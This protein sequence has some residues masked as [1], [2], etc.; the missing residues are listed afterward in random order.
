MSIIDGLRSYHQL[1]GWRGVLLVARARISRKPIQI[2]IESPHLA[3]PVYLRMRTTDVSLYDEIIN[4]AE[5]GFEVR[6]EPRVIVD[7]GANIGL[8]SVFF[9]DRYKQAKVL[10]VEPEPSNFVMLQKNTAAYPNIVPIQAALWD[11][12]T[13]VDLNDPGTGKWG[14][15]A[16]E[17]S[18]Q[19]SGTSVRA[20]TVETLMREACVDYIDILKID[21][22][23]SEKEVFASPASWIDR[24]GV[25]IVELHDRF[26]SGCSRNVYR[27]VSAFPVEWTRGETTFFLREGGGRPTDESEIVR[28]LPQRRM[29][30]S[31]VRTRPRITAVQ[32]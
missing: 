30:S 28:A 14:F 18:E 5:Y 23:G 26:K 15:Q 13:T 22:E 8:T 1:L 16:G 29:T 4:H 6:R 7:A 12:D 11:K 31:G 20:M 32:H 10:A 17:R 21:I 27:A 19:P 3:H 24:V 25:L 9:A 2:T